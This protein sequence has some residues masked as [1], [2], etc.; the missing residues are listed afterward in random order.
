MDLGQ[1]DAW[2]GEP[3]LWVRTLCGWVSQIAFLVPA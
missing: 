3:R 2:A 1:L